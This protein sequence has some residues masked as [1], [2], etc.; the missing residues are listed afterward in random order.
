MEALDPFPLAGRVAL[1]T[2]AGSRDG[3][4]LATARLL[5]AL[6]ASVALTATTERVHE[7]AAEVGGHALG[8]VADLTDEI[9]VARAV[10][11][12]RAG[13]GPPTVLVNN[14]GMTSVGAPGTDESGTALDLSYGAWRASLTRNLDTAFLVTRAVLP[15]MVAGGWGR[16]VMVASVTGP[17]MAMRREAAYA[18][19]KAALVGLTRAVAL[20]HA[21]DGV[22][23]NA[24]APG[25][26]A[27]GSQTGDEARQGRGT[28]V[29]RSG[30]PREVAAVIGFLCGPAA[31]YLTGQCLVVDGGGSIAEERG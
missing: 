1:V 31:S 22:T 26:I 19:S 4:G 15:G 25:W 10:E 30:T 18:A 24:V 17:V 7:R 8:V 16:V 3:I 14:A 5:S 21:A 9:R 27:T 11:E 29:G 2:G 28:P 23:V 20:D 13:L 6:G 12:V